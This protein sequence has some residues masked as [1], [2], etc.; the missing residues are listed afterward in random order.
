MT[1]QWSTEFT[2]SRNEE[3]RK[4][5][6]ASRAWSR[7]A[8]K[9][10]TSSRPTES[11]TRLSLMPSCSRSSRATDACVI[12]PLTYRQTNTHIYTHRHR[13]T[14]THMPMIQLPPAL[15]YGA[16]QILTTYGIQTCI[17]TC[18]SFCH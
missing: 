11:R 15:T 3:E 7:S 4:L 18:M 10:S 14:H 12:I 6:A 1:N 13:T 8:I 2:Q 17:Q 5:T 9:S 16:L